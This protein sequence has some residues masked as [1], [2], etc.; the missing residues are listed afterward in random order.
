MEVTNAKEGRFFR[1]LSLKW[2][3]VLY[4]VVCI[5]AVFLLSISITAF[6]GWLRHDIKQDYEDLYRDE[7]GIQAY[8]V[9]DEEV[10]QGEGLWIYTDDIQNRLSK[11][12]S[13][14]YDLYGI[15]N[16]L[17]VPIASVLCIVAVGAIFYLQR[18][19][20]PLMILDAAS[21]R[22]VA[23]DL[24]FKVEYDSRN[25]FGR[26]AASFETMRESLVETNREIW[27][28]IEGC[29]R[30]NAAFAHDLRTPLTVLR[31]YCDFL[32][33][34]VPEG[35]ISNEKTI[36]TL[37]TMDV[38]LKRMEE[39]TETMSSLQKLEQIELSPE[40]VDV[41][42]LCDKLK[43]ISV[44]LASQKRI[45]FHFDGDGVLYVDLSAVFQTYENLVSNA[46]RYAEHEIKVSCEVKGN[47]FR[48]TVA[49]DGPGFT[50]EALQNATEP[51]FR[52][53]RDI[54]DTTHFGIGLYVCQ[55]LCEK[56]G[57]TLAIENDIGGKVTADFA[58]LRHETIVHSSI[59]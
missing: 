14:L 25:E 52:T 56:H 33:K 46:I 49:D 37:S 8:L 54:S 4:V 13:M 9:P 29:R 6:F 16:V 48:I 59:S 35:K 55:L 40:E 39:Y 17:V 19:K 23:G 57:G 11:R 31:G 18:L 7:L 5:I 58:L 21:A 44:M 43:N 53:E 30:L 26:L 42:S 12:D 51:Y 34:Y 10:E 15:L 38:Y 32:L 41:K 47:V 2:S 1:D 28:I 24:D 36:S 3:F 22:I 50:P 45:D 27:K 20:K